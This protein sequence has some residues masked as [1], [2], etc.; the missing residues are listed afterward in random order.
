MTND[1]LIAM[2]KGWHKVYCDMALN[3]LMKESYMSWSA[4]CRDALIEKLEEE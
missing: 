1:N 2:V 3:S 4:M